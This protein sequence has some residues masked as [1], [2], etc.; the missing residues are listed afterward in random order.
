M[1]FLAGFVTGKSIETY[2]M[3]AV[4]NIAL[5]VGIILLQAPDQDLH[6]L[7][8]GT[9]APVIADGAAFGKTAGA[10][11]ELQFIVLTP[12]DDILLSNA[13][14]GTD[15]GNSL[16]IFAV[17]LRQHGLKLGTVEHAHQGGLHH[18]I[19]MMSQGN[20][21]AAQFFSLGI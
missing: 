6:L 1:D 5:N 19:Q 11:D 18:V 2:C 21:V 17:Q 9:A 14:H 15:Q 8:L 4:I 13:V 16:K 3:E 7:T 12:G 20:F 10:L